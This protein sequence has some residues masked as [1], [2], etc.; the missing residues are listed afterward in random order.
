M[1]GPFLPSLFFS[2]PFSS[3]RPQHRQRCRSRPLH[4]PG[5]RKNGT[6]LGRP[7][8]RGEATQ[9]T[10]G[11]LQVCVMR[12]SSGSRL[13]LNS[14]RFQMPCVHQ[15]SR[16][17]PASAP[18]PRGRGE[19]EGRASPRGREEQEGLLQR[20]TR[21]RDRPLLCP[22]LPGGEGRKRGVTQPIRSAPESNRCGTPRRVA[23]RAA[24]T[25]AP[26][27]SRAGLAAGSRGGGRG[28]SRRSS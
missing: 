16:Q 7:G 11:A 22:P 25:C 8:P 9:R 15:K 3:P 17:L 5:C 23:Y 26:R 19:E 20:A 13:P 14:K 24:H 1:I 2:D 21:P 10:G 18:S 6:H 28:G 4:L 12:E 27:S